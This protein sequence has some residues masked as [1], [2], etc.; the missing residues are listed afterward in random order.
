M[1]LGELL[2]EPQIAG[3]CRTC[4]GVRVQARAS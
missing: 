1:S 3:K 4:G 2:G